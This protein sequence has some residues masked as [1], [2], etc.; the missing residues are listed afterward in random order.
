M[1]KKLIIKKILNI[2]LIINCFVFIYLFFIN[3]TYANENFIITTVNKLPISKID[4]INKA[5]I[6]LYS[7]ERTS[8]SNSLDKYY[9]QAI[10]DLIN[11]RVVFSEGLKINQKIENLVTPKAESILLANFNNSELE[12]NNFLKTLS[13]PKST[14]LANHKKDLILGF[15]IKNK[16]KSQMNNI[17]K[18]VDNKINSRKNQDLYELAE[19]VLNKKNNS[20]LY[21]EIETALENG[22]DFLNIARQISVSPSSK[23]NGKIGWKTYDETSRIIQ[24]TKTIF[25]EGNVFSFSTTDKF[26]FYKILVTR[27][28]GKMSKK[29]NKV[30]LVEVKFPI[31]FRKKEQVYFDVKK[32]LS[33]LLSQNSKCN[34]LLMLKKSNKL[35]ISMNTI[36]SRIADLSP[37]IEYLIKNLG[38]FEVS[39]PLFSGN[40]GFAYIMCDTQKAENDENI[41]IKK[42]KMMNKHLLNL[43]NKIL[44]RLIKQAQISQIQK[45]N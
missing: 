45:I 4:V 13:I 41:Q 25:L 18:L 22:A 5:K 34:N 8:D 29:E 21:K 44:K 1:G 2:K 19:I 7:A 43:S 27:L 3:L 35:K 14:L 15:I 30:L 36:K 11:E 38:L 37:N 12:L 39:K 6:L 24:T 23:F 26:Y 10:K 31:N 9:D 20:K 32:R 16:Y 42:N 40:I 33:N 17:E 28:K